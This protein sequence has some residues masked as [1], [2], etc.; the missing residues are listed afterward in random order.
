MFLYLFWWLQRHLERHW[1]N[2]LCKIR[3]VRSNPFLWRLYDPHIFS[4]PTNSIW[5]IA[6]LSLTISTIVYLFLFVTVLLIA[7]WFPL[8]FLMQ[9]S[10]YC[11]LQRAQF[12]IMQWSSSGWCLLEQFSLL[13][14]GH[15]SPVLKRMMS[16]TMNYHQ[17]FIILCILGFYWN[18]LHFNIWAYMKSWKIYFLLEIT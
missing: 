2:P 6:I 14:F 5:R 18:K 1:G 8:W 7:I 10:F 3:K 4:Y 16:N 9:W 13:L 15:M 12:W 11:M 17:R